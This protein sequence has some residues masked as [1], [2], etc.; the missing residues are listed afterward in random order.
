MKAKNRW[1]TYLLTLVVAVTLCFWSVG[2]DSV[3]AEDTVDTNNTEVQEDTEDTKSVINEDADV[4]SAEE[5][6]EVTSNEIALT[7]YLD[8][9]VK[10]E[11]TQE[12]LAQLVK[13]DKY[14]YSAF[15]S[16]PSANIISDIQGVR[17]A[18]AL[19]QA[20]IN[21]LDNSQVIK[22]I[23]T[24]DV[25][26]TFL[27]GQ[28]LGERYYYPNIKNEAGR[29]G[30]APLASSMTG[31][32]PVPAIIR[33]D[34]PNSIRGRLYFGQL[35]PTEQTMSHFLK[36]VNEIRVY[37]KSE[38]VEKWN[39]LKT[40]NLGTG[41][42]FKYGTAISFNRNVNSDPYSLGDRYCIY[43][44]TDGSTPTVS[45]NI[46]NYN[47]FEFGTSREKFN[48]PVLS[49]GTITIKTRV[50]GYGREASDVT[51][52]RFTGVKSPAAPKITKVTKKKKTITLKW[53]K[54]SGAT[55]YMIYR[56][57]K[58]NGSYSRVKTITSAK[59]VTWKN[60][61]LKK[62]KTYYYKILAYKTV[63]GKKFYSSYS[64]V[65]YKKIK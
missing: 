33:L 2:S 3:F 44:T 27:A 7:I 1:T 13:T 20:G 55:G 53:T 47:N 17:I 14:S 43:Y 49:Q 22:I 50:I 8:D 38:N 16:F 31:K 45:S 28:L 18:E 10:K 5:S 63:N 59:T 35:S 58:K 25:E 56:S 12:E 57:M 15:N 40:T 52:F 29:A 4:F 34:E 65:K 54:V 24:D 41:G 36:Y 37:S 42:T 21:N 61:K 62:K 46:Y 51:T 23:A 11:F 30:K 48:K 64:A 60:K 6:E 19:E 26:E 39:S 32:Q 9:S